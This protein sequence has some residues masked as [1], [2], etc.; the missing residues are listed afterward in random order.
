MKR[1]DTHLLS[2]ES[3]KNDK[4]EDDSHNYNFS[5]SLSESYNS[6][7]NLISKKKDPKSP[8]KLDLENNN[9]SIISSSELQN[10]FLGEKEKEKKE[11][12]RKRPHKKKLFIKLKKVQLNK[13]KEDNLVEYQ[14][15]YTPSPRYDIILD[16]KKLKNNK[17]IKNERDNNYPV[18]NTDKNIQQNDDKCDT[19]NKNK[20]GKE[21]EKEIFYFFY[22]DD[23]EGKQKLQKVINLIMKQRSQMLKVSDKQVL[24]FKN[25]KNINTSSKSSQIGKNFNSNQNFQ[26]YKNMGIERYNQIRK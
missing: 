18:L 8:Y 12:K 23:K 3:E 10:I 26:N 7:D 5:N 20:E 16:N 4:E 9:N 1:H 6:N 22:N 21:K 14:L 17:N 24:T 25:N 19:N 13:G 2:D 11:R 15:T